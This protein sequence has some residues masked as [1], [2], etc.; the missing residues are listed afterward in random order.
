M[1]FETVEVFIDSGRIRR[2]RQLGAS[3]L[4]AIV[5]GIDIFARGEGF[6]ALG[7]QAYSLRCSTAH[8][9]LTCPCS[10]TLFG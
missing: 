2:L 10:D 4:I 9:V 5:G 1:P 8:S 6:E 3:Q 7:D